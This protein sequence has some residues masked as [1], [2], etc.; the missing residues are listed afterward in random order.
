MKIV[1]SAETADVPCSLH[2]RTAES[3]DS[4]RAATVPAKRYRAM[5]Q[6]LYD[7]AARNANGT[8]KQLSDARSSHLLALVLATLPLAFVERRGLCRGRRGAVVR[9]RRDGEGGQG[10]RCTTGEGKRGRRRQVCGGP[11][12]L[13]DLFPPGLRATGIGRGGSSLVSTVVVGAHIK[14]RTV[15][16]SWQRLLG[17][18]G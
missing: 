1:R 17:F 15:M 10:Q 18:G 9:G 5:A 12:G 3:K 13:V 2:W 14:L 4:R 7:I 8:C 16:R 6:R 11:A